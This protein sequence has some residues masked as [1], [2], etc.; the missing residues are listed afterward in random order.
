MKS[1]VFWTLFPSLLSASLV[2][3]VVPISSVKRVSNQATVPNKFII[4]V[5]NL[6]NIPTKRSFTR[7]RPI[8]DIYE[9]ISDTVDH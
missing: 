8:F 2:F 3:G 7:V 9:Q 1:T 6:S 5:D 4:E